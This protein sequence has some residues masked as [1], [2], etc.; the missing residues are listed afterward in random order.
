M[1]AFAAAIRTLTTGSVSCKQL[2]DCPARQEPSLVCPAGSTAE[3][4]C[5]SC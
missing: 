4:I 3:M 1:V 5:S 2:L